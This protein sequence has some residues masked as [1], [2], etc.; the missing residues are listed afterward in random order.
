MIQSHSSFI[1]GLA[2]KTHHMRK[3]TKL[4]ERFEWTKECQQEFTALKDTF[5]NDTLMRHFNPKL[6]T[7]IFVDA[8]RTGLCAILAQGHNIDDSSPVAC[9]SRTTTNVEQ[10]YPQLDLES[11]AV[12]F[13]LRRFRHYIAGGPGVEIITD[14]KPLVSIFASTR[15]G[16]IRTDRIKLRHQDITFKVSWRRGKENPADFLSRHATPINKTSWQQESDELEKTVWFL[17]YAPIQKPSP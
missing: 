10:R 3:L 12:D 5:T 16:S 7:Y 2:T 6:N 8:H 13:G 1:P 4:H 15:I 9:A 14:H 17:Q 11:L